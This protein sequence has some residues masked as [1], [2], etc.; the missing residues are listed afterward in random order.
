VWTL[1]RH[2]VALGEFRDRT[3]MIEMGAGHRNF[4]ERE[5]AR[6]ETCRVMR[7][8]SLPGSTTAARRVASHHN[9]VQFCSKAVTGTMSMFM[10][11]IMPQ[12]Q[13]WH[14]RRR[15]HRKTVAG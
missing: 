3:R 4:L 14:T 7:G 8:K 9:T 2:A 13:L 6:F 5:A 11:G 1:D 10:R 15:D 12:P